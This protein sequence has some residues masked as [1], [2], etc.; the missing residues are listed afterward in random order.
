MPAADRSVDRLDLDAGHLLG[1]LDRPLDTLD[2]RL[3]VRHDPFAE[4]A[5]LVLADP[6]DVD[7]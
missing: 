4:A 2:G 3:D 1:L 7:P 6:D 5:R